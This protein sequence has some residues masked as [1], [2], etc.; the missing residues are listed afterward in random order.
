MKPTRNMTDPDMRAFWEKVEERARAFEKRAP[1]WLLCA[2]CDKC[3][4]V[5]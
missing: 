3:R 1:H 2:G 4:V 5:K